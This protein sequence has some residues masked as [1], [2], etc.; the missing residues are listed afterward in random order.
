MYA[1]RIRP[2][3]AVRAVLG[4]LLVLSAV[5]GG[6]ARGTAAPSRSQGDQIIYGDSLLNGWQSYGWATINYNN[7][8]PTH[9]GSRSISVRATAW[10]ALYIHHAPFTAGLDSALSLWLNGGS[11]GGQQLRLVG[12]LKN[13]PLQPVQLAPLPANSWRRVT[14][15]LAALGVADNP[16]FDGLWVEE[17]TGKTQPVFY[18]DDISLTTIPP[19]SAQVSV[20]AG[21]VLRTVDPRLFGINT[22]A[23]STHLGAPDS[24]SLLDR[25]G[26]RLLR[27]P[28]GTLS[29]TYHWSTDQSVGG[30]QRW[31]AD[32]ST[33]AALV[34]KTQ[35][36]AMITV[37]YGSGTAQEAAALVAWANTV[38]TSKISLGVDAR[39]TNWHTAG[40]WAALRGAAPLAKD[41]GFNF[42]RVRHPASYHL[43]YW[44]I[45]NEVYA[46][47]EED[48]HPRAHDP[49]TY[50]TDA[51]QYITLMKRVDPS[52]KVGVIV[53][54]GEDAYA[55]YYDHPATNPRTGV[56]HNG[57]TP[58][59]LTTLR[60][61]GVTPDFVA[62][63]N[64]AQY[65]GSEN[66]AT[67]LQYARN[68]PAIVAALRAQLDDYLGP[69]GRRV[70]IAC[71][72]ENSVTNN[73]GKQTTS[74]VNGLFLADSLGEVMQTELQML[75]WWDFRD[76]GGVKT[77]NNNSSLYG[78]RY[79]GGYAV[80]QDSR[81]PY[82][83]FYA[84]ELLTHFAAGGEQVLRATSTSRL[85]DAFAT[86]RTD[87]S[88]ALLLINKSPG[89]VL[90]G[91]LTL[92]GFSA[93]G[94]AT[95]Y[96]Y[97]MAQDNASYSGIGSP[98]ITSASTRI[99]GSTASISVLPYTM[100]VVVLRPGR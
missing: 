60:K 68:W 8:R 39:G 98:D 63:H 92:S 84:R 99:A 83:T 20:E 71:T 65:P 76:D 90:Q 72:E 36:S 86:R 24:V 47:W 28:G 100:D 81:D 45:G 2:R 69:A 33:F 27:F 11:S 95:I 59:M 89:T 18:V 6:A 82:P 42:L 35:S 66:D 43:G 77:N 15:S 23:W 41:D 80:L 22:G 34:E 49:F 62:E 75:L 70:A 14:V 9:S 51:A 87:G 31:A 96:S 53:A 38:P 44:E 3:L 94:P 13:K 64:Y 58:V 1:R 78:W 54:D 4:V 67:L 79:Y 93:A 17:G 7:T 74:L 25:M 85:L 40:Y 61:R 12:L 50:A 19:T 30:K 91:S 97:G 5:I 16:L 55:Q 88:L 37:N 52:I 48:E 29:D 26:N 21:Q 46:S 56:V 10:Q 32:I 73:P 57:W